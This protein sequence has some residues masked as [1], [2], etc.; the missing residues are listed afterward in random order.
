VGAL[1]ATTVAV[2]PALTTL[3]TTAIGTCWKVAPTCPARTASKISSACVMRGLSRPTVRNGLLLRSP[4]SSPQEPQKNCAND[5]PMKV[6]DR[7][8]S[9]TPYLRYRT[10]VPQLPLCLAVQ[11]YRTPDMVKIGEFAKLAAARRPAELRQRWPRSRDNGVSAGA[12]GFEPS[13]AHPI[14]T[15]SRRLFSPLRHFLF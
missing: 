1:A 7:A 12:N 15:L 11:A 13:V 4:L 10:I 3:T 8:N 14:E 5:R 9:F 2:M 6:P